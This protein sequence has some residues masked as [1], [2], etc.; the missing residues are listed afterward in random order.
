MTVFALPSQDE[1]LTC[2]LSGKGFWGGP[3]GETIKIRFPAG[4]DK[5]ACDTN[6]YSSLELAGHSKP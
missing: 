1:R 3:Y 6:S 5:S 4:G 2:T